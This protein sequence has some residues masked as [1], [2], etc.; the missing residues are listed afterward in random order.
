MTITISIFYFSPGATAAHAA[1]A[2]SPEWKV[3]SA[4]VLFKFDLHH[5]SKLIIKNYY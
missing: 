3:C 1:I 5:Q 4:G 2:H